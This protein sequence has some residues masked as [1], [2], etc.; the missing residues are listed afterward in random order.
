[1]ITGGVLFYAAFGVARQL[2]YKLEEIRGRISTEC[3]RE[4]SGVC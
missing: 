1:M 3:E 4:I 2:S